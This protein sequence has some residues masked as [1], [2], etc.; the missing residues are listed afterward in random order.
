MK[1]YKDS[2]DRCKNQVCGG[3]PEQKSHVSEDI[4]D[5]P[6]VEGRNGGFRQEQAK[7]EEEA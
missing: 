7:V 2:T 5:E 3:N 4:R 6:P 1:I